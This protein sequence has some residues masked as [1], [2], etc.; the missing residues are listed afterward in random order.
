[1]YFNHI[2]FI[3]KFDIHFFDKVQYIL[4][5]TLTLYL[6]ICISHISK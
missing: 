2:L 6:N 1:M 4:T 3:T 5:F